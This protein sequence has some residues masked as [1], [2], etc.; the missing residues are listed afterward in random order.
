MVYSFIHL[1]VCSSF[2]RSLVRS[3]VRTFARLLVSSLARSSEE[4]MVYHLLG[5]V[6]YT[7]SGAG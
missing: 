3:L 1:F 4:R 7:V 2:V 6:S 5:S